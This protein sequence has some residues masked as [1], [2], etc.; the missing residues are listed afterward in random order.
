MPLPK[1]DRSLC[2]EDFFVPYRGSRL[3]PVFCSCEVASHGI[4]RHPEEWPVFEI[5]VDGV[6]AKSHVPV[7]EQMYC[8]HCLTTKLWLPPRAGLSYSHLLVP[9]LLSLFITS[10]HQDTF[11]C[12]LPLKCRN[13]HECTKGD[14][15]ITKWTYITVN[16][17]AKEDW[18][19][20]HS[21]SQHVKLQNTSF[22]ISDWHI[23]AG[24][25][26]FL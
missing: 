16:S 8:C 19:H 4:P 21:W 25:N 3:I 5:T 11:C 13:A 22:M 12:C 9:A 18:N 24:T 1:K 14:G 17:G 6:A 10:G 20:K 26:H 7:W 23:P 2:G 15:V